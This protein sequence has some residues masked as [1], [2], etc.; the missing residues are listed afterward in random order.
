M[1][2]VRESKGSVGMTTDKWEMMEA[3]Q[4]QWFKQPN[5]RTVMKTILENDE[6]RTTNCKLPVF[7]PKNFRNVH[8]N[9]IIVCD[10][11]TFLKH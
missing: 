10:G 6:C 11:T 2:P 1:S 8:F 4:C 7:I 9:A 5:T 3:F